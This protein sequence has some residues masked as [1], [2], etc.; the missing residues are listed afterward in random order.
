MHFD[1]LSIHSPVV[2][3][4]RCIP[5]QVP[6]MEGC[7]FHTRQSRFA[8]L[9]W[10]HDPRTAPMSWSREWNLSLCYHRCLWSSRT[11]SCW[12]F[13]R[14]E[15]AGCSI[16]NFAAHAFRLDRQ[17]AVDVKMASGHSLLLRYT[18]CCTSRQTCDTDAWSSLAECPA[19]AAHKVLLSS[20]RE[21]G[22]WMNSQWAKSDPTY[23]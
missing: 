22:E 6:D 17:M 4:Y 13:A 23:M 7:Y 15:A 20:T 8:A 11:L 14:S 16:P 18:S 2:C 1:Y 5:L 10:C 21:H 3:Q 19:S 12:R 9:K